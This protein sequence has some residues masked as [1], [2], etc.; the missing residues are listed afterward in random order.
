MAP[1]SEIARQLLKDVPDFLSWNKALEWMQE[2]QSLLENYRPRELQESEIRSL[3]WD[4]SVQSTSPFGLYPLK[5]WRKFV[6]ST[7]FSDVVSYPQPVDQVN[8]E[9]LLFV[10]HTF[11]EGFRTW[12]IELAQNM[13]WPVGYSGWYP[14]HESAFEIFEKH[15]E[16]LRDRMV[17]PYKVVGPT[18]QNPYLY[19]FS[20]SAAPQLKGS[21]LT[22]ALMKAFIKDIDAAQPAGLSCI[23]VSGDGVR[24]A[25][26]LGLTQT[27][28]LNL[29]GHLEGIFTRR[30]KAQESRTD[31]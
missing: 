13:W 2:G 20:F 6:L 19:L 4:H 27:G 31:F 9:R 12:W 25:S 3:E 30:S 11:P 24:I 26:R 16:K 21:I 17:V 5:S 8:F 28:T 7:Y 10:M 18:S 22:K 14:M 15:P 23:T 29:N 1:S